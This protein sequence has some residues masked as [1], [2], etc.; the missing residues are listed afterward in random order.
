MGE[1]G[2]SGGDLKEWHFLA[3][4]LMV[5]KTLWGSQLRTQLLCMTPKILIL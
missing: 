5:H 3:L 4:T 2:L 1:A